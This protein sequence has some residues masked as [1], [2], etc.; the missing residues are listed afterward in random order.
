MS[1][2][3]HRARSILYNS[4]GDASEQKTY[5]TAVPVRADKDQIGV[6]LRGCVDD[7]CTGISLDDSSSGVEL[8]LSQPFRNSVDQDVRS[9]VFALQKR[10][11]VAHRGGE[12]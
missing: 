5:K 11:E 1:D 4:L 3:A 9:L 6:P 7:A 2:D 10:F 8:M 12:G